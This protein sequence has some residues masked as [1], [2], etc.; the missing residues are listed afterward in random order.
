MQ[1]ILALEHIDSELSCQF[2]AVFGEIKWKKYGNI[3]KKI[4]KNIILLCAT[5][6]LRSNA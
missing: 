3:S 6:Y 1:F 4:G 2:N 5:G